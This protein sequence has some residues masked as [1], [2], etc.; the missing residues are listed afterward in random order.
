L[1]YQAQHIEKFIVRE[2]RVEKRSIADSLLLLLGAGV[3]FSS[4][5]RQNSLANPGD[6]GLYGPFSRNQNRSFFDAASLLEGDKISPV[7]P[8]SGN[9]FSIIQIVER[10]SRSP[11]ALERVYTQ[12]ESILIN[13]NQEAA[14]ALGIDGL[15]KVYSVH[16]NM[17]LL[18]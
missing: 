4:L 16:K 8:S 11:L 7:L 17:S 1:S 9:N 6:G 3:D 13:K 10:V 18:N 12:I 14:R 5:A 15:L 2:I